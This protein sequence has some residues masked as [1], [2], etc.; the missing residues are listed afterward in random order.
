MAHRAQ[1]CALE[2]PGNTLLPIHA[3]FYTVK[4][5]LAETRMSSRLGIADFQLACSLKSHR[6]VQ[7]GR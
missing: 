2:D 1:L 3:L 4:G 7:T 6:A 5:F